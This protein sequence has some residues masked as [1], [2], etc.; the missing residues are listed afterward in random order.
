VRFAGTRATE[1]LAAQLLVMLPA[2][3]RDTSLYP[4][5]MPAIVEGRGLLERR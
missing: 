2:Q 1:S 3:W 4:G 5:G